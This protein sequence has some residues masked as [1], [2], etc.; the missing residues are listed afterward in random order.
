MDPPVATDPETGGA[1]KSGLKT[2]QVGGEY[3]GNSLLLYRFPSPSCSIYF[4]A[5]RSQLAAFFHML[6][7]FVGLKMKVGFT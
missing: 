5:L 4:Q 7:D 1:S 2:T 3:A 6:R